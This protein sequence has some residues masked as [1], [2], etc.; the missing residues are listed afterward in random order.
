MLIS[1]K[2]KNSV[3]SLHTPEHHLATKRRE[4]P[5]LTT[6]WIDLGTMLLSEKSRHRR[7]HSVGFHGTGT[8]TE[9]GF[10]VVR[11]WGKEM[12]GMVMGMSSPLGVAQSW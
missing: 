12:G 7:T 11:G 6:T 10:L 2:R 5:T 1:S 8:S 9:S 3:W 4:A